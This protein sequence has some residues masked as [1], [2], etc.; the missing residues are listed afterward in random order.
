[1]SLAKKEKD[2]AEKSFRKEILAEI[3]GSK[4]PL[5]LLRGMK[6]GIENLFRA[7]AGVALVE[8]DK[9]LQYRK[10]QLKVIKLLILKR[11]G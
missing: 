6:L 9:V 4:D 5:E 3:K 2:E 7:T 11:N 8:G 10:I 1:M